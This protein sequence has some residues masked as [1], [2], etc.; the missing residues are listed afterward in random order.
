MIN[1]FTCPSDP[2]HTLKSTDNDDRFEELTCVSCGLI[3]YKS[4]KITQKCDILQEQNT[5]KL[6]D[7]MPE[8]Y[9]TGSDW[10]DDVNDEE[11][12]FNLMC[13]ETNN[14]YYRNS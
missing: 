10:Q 1:E 9:T 11:K 13:S 12:S 14:L 6:L 8:T 5:N 3:L 7:I 2:K 4:K